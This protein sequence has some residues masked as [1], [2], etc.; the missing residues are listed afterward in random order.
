MREYYDARADEYDEWDLGHG[1][2]S[3]LDRPG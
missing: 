3:Q 2:F 1:R